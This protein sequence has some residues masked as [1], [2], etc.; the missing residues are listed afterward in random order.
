M[1]SARS[2]SQTVPMRLCDVLGTKWTISIL[3]ELLAGPQRFGELQSTLDGISPRTL[4]ERL[5]RLEAQGF[6]LR[7]SYAEAPPRVEYSLTAKGSALAPVIQAMR[8]FE[9]EFLG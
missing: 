8:R 3:G 6:V 9:S 7:H 2:V 1:P 4:T 5:R